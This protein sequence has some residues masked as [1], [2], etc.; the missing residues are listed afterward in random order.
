MQIS[1]V[2]FYER[3][4]I[5]GQYNSYFQDNDIDPRLLSKGLTEQQIQQIRNR[6]GK[7]EVVSLDLRFTKDLKLFK[8]PKFD[9]LYQL[10]DAWSSHNTLPFKGSFTDQPSQ[11]LEYFTI[12]DQL[13]YEQDKRAKLKADREIKKRQ[14]SNV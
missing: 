5:V 3:S 12:F 10:Y 1:S 9:F 6:M 14:N 13:K 8:H 2:S 7:K 11:I 4:L